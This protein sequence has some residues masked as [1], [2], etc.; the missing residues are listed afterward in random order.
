MVGYFIDEDERA[1][2]DW[3]LL[4]SKAGGT[5]STVDTQLVTINSNKNLCKYPHTLFLCNS[6]TKNEGIGTN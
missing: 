4:E 6:R 5:L 2:K 3:Y 1:R